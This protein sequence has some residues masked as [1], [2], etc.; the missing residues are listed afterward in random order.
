M[1]AKLLWVPK[2]SLEQI[3]LLSNIQLVFTH[4]GVFFVQYILDVYLLDKAAEL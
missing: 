2:S 1:I 4:F 3:I